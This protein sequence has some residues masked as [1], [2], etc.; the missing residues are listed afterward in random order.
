M[1]RGFDAILNG[2]TRV[3]GV[4]TAALVSTG[5]GL[6]VAESSMEGTNTAALAAL[7]ASLVSRLG[8]AM[9]AAGQMPPDI[10]HLEAERGHLL[11]RPAPA[12]LLL[13]AVAEVT[14]NVSL[15]RLALLDAAERLAP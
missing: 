10:I 2:I 3:Q 1:S 12:D 4:R 7:T 5:D 9:A 8:K 6:V 15:L 11:A 13:V 14:T